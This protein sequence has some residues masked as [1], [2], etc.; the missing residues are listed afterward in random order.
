[1]LTRIFNFGVLKSCFGWALSDGQMMVHLF[2]DKYDGHYKKQAAL[3][4]LVGF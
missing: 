4:N 2:D 1:M 3:R